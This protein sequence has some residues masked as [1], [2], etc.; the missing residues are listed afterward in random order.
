MLPKGDFTTII[1]Y[2]AFIYVRLQRIY[3]IFFVCETLRLAKGKT[4]I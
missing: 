1:Y 2:P 4:R 3:R